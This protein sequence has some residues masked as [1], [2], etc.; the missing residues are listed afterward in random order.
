M[1][2]LSHVLV[3]LGPIFFSKGGNIAEKL[4]G[5]ALIPQPAIQFTRHQVSNGFLML[6][7]SIM[8]K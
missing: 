5:G 7:D 3:G 6:G 4:I 8:A 2:T 1:M